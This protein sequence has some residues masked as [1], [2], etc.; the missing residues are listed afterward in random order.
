M[1]MG[2]IKSKTKY[3]EFG[4]NFIMMF[5]PKREKPPQEIKVIKNND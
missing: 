1:V 2:S 3:P 5:D 4:N